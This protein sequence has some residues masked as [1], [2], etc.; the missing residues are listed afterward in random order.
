M[1]KLGEVFRKNQ[2]EE[3][4]EI[5]PRRTTK[6]IHY[7]KLTGNKYQYCDARDKNEIEMLADLIEADGMVLQDVLVRKTDKDEYEIIGGHKRTA[8]CKLL[9][10]ERGKKN[11]EFLP[12]LVQDVSDVRAQFQVYSSNGHHEETP[13]EVMHKLEKMQYLLKNY[14]EEFPELQSGRMVERLAA[15]FHMKKTTVGEYQSIAKN[16]SEEA[17]EAFQEGKLDKSAAVT[18]AGLDENR[19]QEVLA[20][21]VTTDTAIKTYIKENLE[22]TEAEI[23]ALYDLLN[24]KESDQAD[25][26]RLIAELKKQKKNSGSVRDD[27]WWNCNATHITLYD[28]NG[29][30]PRSITWSRFGKLLDQYIPYTEVRQEEQLQGQMSVE[31]YPEVLPEQDDGPK[32]CITEK[33][34]SG[35]CGAAAYCSTDYNCCAECD[36]SCN[37][38]CGWLD[39]MCDVAQEEQP[40]VE[41]TNTDCPPGQSSCP[42]QNWGTSAENQHEGQKECAKCW[43]RYKELH[44]DNSASNELNK[45]EEDTIIDTVA[46]EIEEDPSDLY[47]E[48]SEKTDLDIAIG[49]NERNKRY[50]KMA[51]EAFGPKDIRVRTFKVLIAALACYIYELDEVMNPPEEPE[52]PELPK[53]KNN[54][55]RKEWLNNYKE[56]GLWYRDENIDVNYYKYDFVD[57]SRLVVAEY[58]QRERGWTPEK[59]DEHQYH[60]IK[61][62]REGYG[63]RLYDCKYT[64]DTDS[65][66]CLIEFLKK[67]QKK[68]K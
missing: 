2:T 16:L 48:V 53:L 26:K 18:L 27:I 44:K 45:L 35:R 64:H 30:H 31:D 32:K 59:I 19:Q 7:T 42:R 40:A 56:W 47:E 5:H 14:P 61:K 51:E 49:E 62:D 52:Q 13:Y 29:N 33:S 4:T 38:R 63:S 36:E 10:E 25:R 58:P 46:E 37:S 67:I 34:K 21:G 11:F 57:G 50:L 24:I 17:M 12:C 23:H 54:V 28:E 39:D 1:A 65:E 20:A 3:R 55:Q 41:N 15:L 9:V 43:K 60:L 68:E 22:P 66:T 6:W 8:A